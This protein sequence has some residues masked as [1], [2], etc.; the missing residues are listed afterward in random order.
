M[1]ASVAVKCVFSRS[2]R[3]P[4]ANQP[5]SIHDAKGGFQH[6]EKPHSAPE[7]PMKWPKKQP[8]TLDGCAQT[9]GKAAAV[10]YALFL[11]RQPDMP[12]AD[13]LFFRIH[14]AEYDFFDYLCRQ[15]H[16]PAATGEPATGYLPYS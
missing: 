3:A 14:P 15:Q 16:P 8:E 1:H 10:L 13:R 4:F 6:H 11:F 12:P 7:I 9:T 2:E 5:A